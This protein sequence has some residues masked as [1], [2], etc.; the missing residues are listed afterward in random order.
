MEYHETVYLYT[1]D[2]FEFE[3]LCTKIVFLCSHNNFI[4]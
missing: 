2:G 1:I 4:L 3:N